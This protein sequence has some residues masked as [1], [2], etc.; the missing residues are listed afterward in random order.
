MTG[1]QDLGHSFDRCFIFFPQPQ[2]PR[3]DGGAQTAPGS[4]SNRAVLEDKPAE[5]VCLA[6]LPSIPQ[7]KEQVSWFSDFTTVSIRVT[8]G[9][10]R[11]ELGLTGHE[12]FLRVETRDPNLG[13]RDR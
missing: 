13:I 3:E 10:C 6:E 4:E 12:A 9:L 11:T 8:R 7:L 5:E 2:R 1:N